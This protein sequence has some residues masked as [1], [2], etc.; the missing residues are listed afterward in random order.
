MREIGRERD[1]QGGYREGGERLVV[2]VLS[3]QEFPQV[4]DFEV[5]HDYLLSSDP[6]A[7]IRIR[8]R[9]QNGMTSL[10]M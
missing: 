6:Q 9:G 5:Q 10:L 8:K 4:Q 2:L 3:L 1:G 7:Q